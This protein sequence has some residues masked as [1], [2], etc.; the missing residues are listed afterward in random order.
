VL[1]ISIAI[2][3]T[4]SAQDASR[5]YIEPTGWS[6]GTDVGMSDL[7]GDVGTKSFI[8]HY[9]NSKY[10]NKV[11]AMGGM[12]GRYT[13]HPCF[14]LRYMFNYGSLY[15]TDK[16]NY[17]KAKV[18]TDQGSDAFQRYARNQDA[19]AVI[20]ENTLLMEFTPFR[21]NPES[22]KAHK[23]GQVYL[24]AGVA[25][26]HFEPYSTV[27]GSQTWVKTYELDLEGQGFGAGYPPKYSLWQFGIPLAIGYRWDLGKHLNLGIEYMYRM[28][29]TDYL[30]GVSGKYVSSAAFQEHLS[31]KNAI[32]AEQ[33]ADKGQYAVPELEGPNIPGNA[34]GNPGNKDA[35][36]TITITF[37]YKVHNATRQWWTSY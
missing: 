15:A 13:V 22:K 31:P 26:F 12:F 11:T 35:Y 32:L 7:W 29:F 34:R 2:C 33:V 14:A 8:D 18:A 1:L 37:Y 21:M 36:S 3:H 10:F 30:D 16:W 20:F 5:I 27:A 25:F 9:A 6:I 23:R 4:A 19:K 17:D 24:A 28:T